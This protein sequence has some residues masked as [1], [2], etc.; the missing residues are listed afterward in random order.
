MILSC[1]SLDYTA[2]QQG[3]SF[4]GFTKGLV[5]TANKQPWLFLTTGKDE[6]SLETSPYTPNQEIFKH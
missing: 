2:Q 3:L 1:K 4:R 6:S 5:C